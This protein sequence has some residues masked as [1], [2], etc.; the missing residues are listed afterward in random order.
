MKKLDGSNIVSASI[1]D[2]DMLDWI[3]R[4]RNLLNWL[5]VADEK[6]EYGQII[7]NYHGGKIVSY[8]LCPR[9]RMEAEK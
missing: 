5:K 8:D 1:P 6:I 3:N 7:I 4:N 2:K 9:E